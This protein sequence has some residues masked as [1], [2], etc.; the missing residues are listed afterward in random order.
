MDL[1]FV[2]IY[3]IDIKLENHIILNTIS[4]RKIDRSY[5]HF[6]LQFAELQYCNDGQTSIDDVNT[7][8]AADT[9]TKFLL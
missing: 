1:D 5:K 7:K 6:I 2:Y 8:C 4:K 3:L 9:Y